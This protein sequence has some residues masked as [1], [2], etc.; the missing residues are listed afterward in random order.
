MACW[1]SWFV[2]QIGGTKLE[3]HRCADRTF[4]PL[5]FTALATQ[6]HETGL[7][8]IRLPI[9]FYGVVVV[10]VEYCVQIVGGLADAQ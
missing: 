5:L 7:F 1:V 4:V 9:A 6:Y 8:S 3:S 2:D 10:L